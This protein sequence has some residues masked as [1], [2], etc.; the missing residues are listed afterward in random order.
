MHMIDAVILLQQCHCEERTDVSDA[1]ISY[2][3]RT[4]AQNA[5]KQKRR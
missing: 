4:Y 3:E 5:T 2:T 1:A